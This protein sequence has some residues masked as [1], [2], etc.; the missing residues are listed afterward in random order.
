M[1]PGIGN[2]S[3]MMY[4]PWHLAF[5]ISENGKKWSQIGAGTQSNG[6]NPSKPDFLADSLPVWR[7][8][9]YNETVDSVSRESLLVESH[10]LQNGWLK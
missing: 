6:P 2:T 4:S 3:I 1:C 5:R 10:S 8:K 9:R 7:T